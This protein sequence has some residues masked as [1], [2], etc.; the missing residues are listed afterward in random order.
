ML[1]MLIFAPAA[2]AAATA[3]VLVRPATSDARRVIERQLAAPPRGSM[4]GGLSAEEAEA[5]QA[6]NVAQIGTTLT[7]DRTKIK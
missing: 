7:T 6:R 3:P 1:G 5:V 2:V 4:A